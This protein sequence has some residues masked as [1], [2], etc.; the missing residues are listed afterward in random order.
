MLSG[1][2][3]SL[4]ASMRSWSHRL[5]DRRGVDKSEMRRVATEAEMLSC[6]GHFDEHELHLEELIQR[7]PNSHISLEHP[8]KSAGRQRY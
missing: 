1:L 8:A 2:M 5:R 3:M 4:F 6:E 7:F